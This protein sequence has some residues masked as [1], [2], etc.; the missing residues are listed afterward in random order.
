MGFIRELFNDNNTINEK[1]VIGFISFIFMI[2]TLI[3]DLFTG[4][5]GK[6]LV[7]HEYIFDGFLVMTLGSFGIASIDKWIVNNKKTT[8]EG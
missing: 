6:E 1:S 8:E 2:V 3:L 7:I 5:M 4:Y